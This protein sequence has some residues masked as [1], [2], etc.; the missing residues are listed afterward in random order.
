[1]LLLIDVETLCGFYIPHFA[2][3]LSSSVTPEWPMPP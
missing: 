2:V 3:R 1:M